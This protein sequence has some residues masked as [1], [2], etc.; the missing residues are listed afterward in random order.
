MTMYD[1]RARL[2]Q[3]V[4][5]EVRSHFGERVFKTLVPRSIRLGEAPSFGE[6][7]LAYA[8]TSSGAVAYDQLAEE[9]LS[10]DHESNQLKRSP[11]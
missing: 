4:I 9:I 2:A 10:S 11:D 8:P 7:I 1:S 5:E 6:P 3:Q